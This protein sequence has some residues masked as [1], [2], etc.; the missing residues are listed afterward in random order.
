MSEQ[1]Q[2]IIRLKRIHEFRPHYISSTIPI[3]P[4]SLIPEITVVPHSTSPYIL[5]TILYLR[6]DIRFRAEVLGMQIEV[7]VIIGWWL[8]VHDK[9]LECR[10]QYWCSHGH[11]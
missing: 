1:I 6:C 2:A 9:C 11:W 4:P 3:C 10:L 8:D 5:L 7:P